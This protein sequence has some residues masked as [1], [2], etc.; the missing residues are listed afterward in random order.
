MSTSIDRNLVA[1]QQIGTPH[2]GRRRGDA[3]LIAFN[4]ALSQ[5]DE[6]VAMQLLAEYKRFNLDA[7]F[8]LTIER[9][10]GREHHESVLEYLWGRIRSR[11]V[12][13]RVTE[14]V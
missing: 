14:E 7:P 2:R 6:D 11:F 12:P 3:I 10:R 13:S 1:E 4:H 8:E 5:G 9:R